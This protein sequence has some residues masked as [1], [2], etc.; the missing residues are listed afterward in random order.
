MQIPKQTAAWYDRLTTLQTGYYYPWHSQ[1]DPD[2]GEDRYVALVHRYLRSDAVV[3]D[4]ACGHGAQTLEFAPYCRTI[5]G[6]DRTAEWIALAREQSRRTQ[7]PDATFILYDSSPNAN[8]GQ[9][10]LPVTDAS[11]D[12]IVCS[13]GPF[14]WIDDARRAAHPGATLIMLVPD[15]TPPTPWWGAL[16][17]VLRWAGAPDRH[18][19]RTT[20]EQRL[21]TNGLTLQCWWEFDVPEYFAYPDDLYDWLTWGEPPEIIPSRAAMRATL[22]QIFGTH[23]EPAG[24]PIRHRRYVWLATIP[25]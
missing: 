14:H 13:K 1:P 24:V 23:G 12:L 10:H 3:L 16:P 2:H 21:A 11:C 17:Q 6:Y 15:A 8:G 22:K 4:V 7:Q 5:V 9:A 25:E 18:W 19:A 20:I